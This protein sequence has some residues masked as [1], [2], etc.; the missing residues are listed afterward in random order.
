MLRAVSRAVLPSFE[1]DLNR[2]I[3]KELASME[4]NNLL[5]PQVFGYAQPSAAGAFRGTQSR[6]APA[7]LV[8]MELP[9]PKKQGLFHE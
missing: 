5:A 1:R 3:G 4:V 2:C 6:S 8:K 9:V 7:R